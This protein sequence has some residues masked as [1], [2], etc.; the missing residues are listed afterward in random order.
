VEPVANARVLKS[1]LAGHP[2]AIR[3]L[4]EALTPVVQARVARALFRV[5]CVRAQNRDLRQ[6]VA[7]LTQEVFLAL[8]AEDGRA[9]RAWDPS[10]GLSLPGF[11][12]LLTGNIVASLV[13]S[14]RRNPWSEEAVGP[15]D[16]EQRA[17]EDDRFDG[18]IYSRE[19]L[20]KIL[21]R[22]RAELSDRDRLLFELVVLEERPC[23]EIA[24]RTGMT[25]AA[26]YTWRSRLVSRVRQLAAEL[27]RGSERT[28]PE[29]SAP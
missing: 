16:L 17:G 20:R 1:A 21:D 15:S 11:V 8:F 25:A 23:S 2:V 28:Q 9:L 7:D 6:E 18:L 5:G 24:A 3:E 10:R 27:E 29:R 14:R 26:I 12:G 22:L 4:V 19:L 13:R